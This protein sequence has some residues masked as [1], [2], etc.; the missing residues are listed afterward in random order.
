M[1]YSTY[2]TLSHASRPIEPYMKGQYRLSRPCSPSHPAH[3]EYLIALP[4]N[5]S[6]RPRTMQ[7]QHGASHR[8]SK[9]SAFS[10]RIK[11]LTHFAFSHL[12]HMMIGIESG[13]VVSS[14]HRITSREY[15][16]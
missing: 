15:T 6:K 2:I 3:G 9:Y 1:L 11:K 4:V 14:I 10:A 13:S 7:H 12:F 8:C 5:F 16:T